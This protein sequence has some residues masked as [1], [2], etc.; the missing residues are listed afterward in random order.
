[1]P[2]SRKTN[3]LN[4]NIVDKLTAIKNVNKTDKNSLLDDHTSHLQ[5]FITD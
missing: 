1:M 4:G 2:Y 3:R 5:N